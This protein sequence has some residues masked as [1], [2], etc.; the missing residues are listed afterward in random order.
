MG[1]IG[2][3][4]IKMSDLAAESGSAGTNISLNGVF[5]EFAKYGNYHQQDLGLSSNSNL[6]YNVGIP[7]SSVADMAMAGLANYDSDT[8]MMFSFN[9]NVMLPDWDIYFEVFVNDGLTTPGTVIVA[10]AA[11]NIF[12]GP[13]SFVGPRPPDMQT[14]F[15]SSDYYIWMEI[16]ATYTGGGRPAPPF[17]T[18]AVQSLYDLY[19]SG[20]TVL[21]P[22]ENINGWDLFNTGAISQNCIY[23]TGFASLRWSRCIGCDIVIQ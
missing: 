14:N 2:N 19:P 1:T 6:Y 21:Y 5:G 23:D 18:V 10:G 15:A 20:S 12:S 7:Y 8:W 22:V 17:P 16:N 13:Q 4:N 9:F 11:Y 3:T